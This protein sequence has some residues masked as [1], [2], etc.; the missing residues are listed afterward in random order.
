MGEFLAWWQAGG[1]HGRGGIGAPPR[2]YLYTFLCFSFLSVKRV[3]ERTK[4]K[5]MGKED[6]TDI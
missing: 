2:R 1:L 4:T 5:Q 6:K 3:K